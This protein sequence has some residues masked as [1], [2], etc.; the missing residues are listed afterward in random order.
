MPTRHTDVA[1]TGREHGAGQAGRHDSGMEQMCVFCR[2]AAHAAHA[3]R[4]YEDELAVAI[5]DTNP[6]RR[7]HALVVP[8]RHVSDVLADGGAEA[9]AEV[10]SAVHVTSRLL[11]DRLGG[12]GITLFQSNGAA[13]GQVVFHLHVHLLPRFEGE[14]Q[15]RTLDRDE[16]ERLRLADTYRSLVTAGG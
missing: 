15:L 3:Y 6:V 10:A 4:L 16:R 13:A 7:G 9:W 2:I 14:P 5:L 8:R 11:V 12:A 1:A